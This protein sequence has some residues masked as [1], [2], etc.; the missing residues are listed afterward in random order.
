MVQFHSHIFKATTAVRHSVSYFVIEYS[1]ISQFHSEPG[2]ALVDNPYS[3]FLR[4]RAVFST[5]NEFGYLDITCS[6]GGGYIHL[7]MISLALT[8]AAPSQAIRA[9]QSPAYFIFFAISPLLLLF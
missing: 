6:F 1:G 8:P 2:F 7:Y 5:R 3:M 9:I 4:K